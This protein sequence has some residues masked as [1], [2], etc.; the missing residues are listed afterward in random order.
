[1]VTLVKFQSPDEAYLARMRLE[2]SGIEA[3]IADETMVS[4]NWLYSNAIG[5]IRLQVREE[6]QERAMEILSLT[7]SERGIVTCPHCGSQNIKYRKIG[8]A[9]AIGLIIGFILPAKSNELDCADCKR[10]FESKRL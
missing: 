10:S 4:M 2:G 7:P 8:P 6:D 9:A 3:F 1:M 5:G